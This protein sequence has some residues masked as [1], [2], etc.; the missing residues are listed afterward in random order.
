[1]SYEK[2]AGSAFE[3]ELYRLI[4]ARRDEIGDAMLIGS[5]HCFEDYKYW[6]GYVAAMKEFND[7]IVAAR[8]KTNK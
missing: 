5:M 8:K 2:Y 3:V 7:M 6:C 4:K 1:M